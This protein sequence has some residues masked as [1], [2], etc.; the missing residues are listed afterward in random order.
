MRV[1]RVDVFVIGGGG[2]GSDVTAALAGAGM[3][4]AMAD[5]EALGGECANFGCDPSKAMLKAARVAALAREQASSA[6]G[7]GPS[8]S[9]SPP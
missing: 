3:N 8:R 9:T 6:S 5:R 4:V 7:W 1:E 2:T